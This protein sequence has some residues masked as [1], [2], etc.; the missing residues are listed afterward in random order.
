MKFLINDLDPYNLLNRVL[1]IGDWITVFSTHSSTRI[2]SM[3]WAWE[4][5]E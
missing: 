4:G 5:F 3:N 1:E 2:I